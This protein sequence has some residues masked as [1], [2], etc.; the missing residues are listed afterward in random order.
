MIS[1][2]RLILTIAAVS[3]ALTFGA[4]TINAQ[5]PNP[6]CKPQDLDP[7]CV[8]PEHYK[9]IYENDEVRILKFDDTPGHK[10][11]KH[12]HKYP[13]RLYAITPSLRQ[14]YPECATQ[15]PPPPVLL[16]P[17]ED[18][19][20]PP[21]NPHP[22]PPVTH[23]ETNVGVTDAH[24]IIVEYKKNPPPTTITTAPRRRPARRTRR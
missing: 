5:E 3:A 15:N 14:F 1:I 8:D 6:A 13:L 23:C 17:E 10:V 12:M 20:M 2:A 24:L 18:N 4:Q 9:V 19:A 11:P 7:V 21:L 22:P 16:A